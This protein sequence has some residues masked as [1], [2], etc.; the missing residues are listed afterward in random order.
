L[1]P[2]PTPTPT[3]YYHLIIK[4]LKYI[5][6]IIR[7]FIISKKYNKINLLKLYK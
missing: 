6:L 5:L 1:G 4:N 3:P 7:I 2:T